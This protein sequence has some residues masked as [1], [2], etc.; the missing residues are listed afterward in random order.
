VII[1]LRSCSDAKQM[2]DSIALRQRCGRAKAAH[3][4]RPAKLTNHQRRQVLARLDRGEETL[5]EIARSHAV[6]HVTIS[7]IKARHAAG[8]DLI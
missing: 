8:D 1:E 6:C 5:T 3:V 2:C 4:H 7:Q